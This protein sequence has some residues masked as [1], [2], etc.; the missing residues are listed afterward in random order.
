MDARARFLT[1]LTF[2]ISCLAIC[3]LSAS[4]LTHNWLVAKVRMVRDTTI[5]SVFLEQEGVHPVDNDKFHGTVQFGLFYGK[6]VLNYG[7]GP[8]A[9]GFSTLCCLASLT[10]WTL[11]FQWKLSHN[12]MSPDERRQ[13]W[14]SAGLATIGWS[15]LLV[16][17][18]LLLNLCNVVVIILADKK[19]WLKPRTVPVHPKV[20][21]GAVIML[22]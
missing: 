17:L 8:R 4:L 9:T 21:Q 13:Q 22:Y 15:F 2:L 10:S 7:Y 14:N 1:F 6:K 16:V 3:L 20:N 5:D 18:G 19:P 11:E 12:V